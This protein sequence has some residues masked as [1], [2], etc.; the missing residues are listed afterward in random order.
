[1]KPSHTEH[2][3]V[4]EFRVRAG[5]EEKFEATYGPRGGWAELFGRAPGYLGTELLQDTVEPRRYLTIDRWQSAEAAAR[6]RETHAD[7]YA[8]LDAECERW[9]EGETK[10]GAWSV[11]R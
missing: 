3:L 2:V 6:F 5:C 9:T 8:A 4:W 1:M 7:Q 11:L 10:L